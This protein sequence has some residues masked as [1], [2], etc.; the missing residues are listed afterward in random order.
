MDPAHEAIS[1]VSITLGLWNVL[2]TLLAGI[3]MW[4]WNRLHTELDGKADKSILEIVREELASLRESQERE[5][6]DLRQSGET[7]ARAQNDRLDRLIQITLSNRH[8]PA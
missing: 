8:P 6:R 3:I 7:A 5:L 4:N 1:W 2:L